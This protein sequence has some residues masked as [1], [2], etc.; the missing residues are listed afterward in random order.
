MWLWFSFHCAFLVRN[1]DRQHSDLLSAYFLC[2]FRGVLAF[3]VISMLTVEG[4]FNRPPGGVFALPAE[5]I[6]SDLQRSRLD[7]RPLVPPVFDDGRVICLLCTE[8][9]KPD[10][11]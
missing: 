10:S 9:N 4:A 1:T 8:L 5:C 2:L 11:T 7:S 6:C 3:V